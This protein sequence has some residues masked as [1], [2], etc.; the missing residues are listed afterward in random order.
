M[1]DMGMY[2][3]DL[4]RELLPKLRMG[5]WVR[6][7][8][9]L[10]DLVANPGCGKSPEQRQ[11]H[12]GLRAAGRIKQEVLAGPGRVFGVA[13][14]F[15]VFPAAT[16]QLRFLSAAQADLPIR[17]VAWIVPRNIHFGK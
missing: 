6:D 17:R 12:G 16:I 4:C 14:V 11:T 10:T 5:I 8:R 2:W 15:A 13:Q 7:A 9:L 1:G 3:P